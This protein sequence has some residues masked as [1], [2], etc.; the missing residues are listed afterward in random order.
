MAPPAVQRLLSGDRGEQFPAGRAGQRVAA[1]RRPPSAMTRSS[2]PG[3]ANS[4]SGVA[5]S[6]ASDWY[7]RAISG[8]ARLAAKR[9]LADRA[10]AVVG[11]V[12]RRRRRRRRSRPAGAGRTR[13]SPG[14]AARPPCVVSLVEPPGQLRRG[15]AGSISRSRSRRQQACSRPI[16]APRPSDGLVHAQASPTATTPS[17]PARRRRRGGGTG[18]RCRPS[19]RRRR[20]ARRRP[21]A[22][23]AGTAPAPRSNGPVAQRRAAPCPGCW[24]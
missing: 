2:S 8:S 19:R 4:S 24:S 11:A 22:R 16:E 21:S 20:S 3:S 9:G 10:T 17:R 12:R 1:G 13:G 18:P 15:R 14:T 5:S 6:D 7:A 23:P